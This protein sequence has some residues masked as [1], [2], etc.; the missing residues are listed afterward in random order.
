MASLHRDPRGRSPYWFVAYRRG[1]GIR[2]LKSTKETNLQCA[3][4]VAQMFVRVAEEE[5]RADTTKDLLNGIV[6][7]TLRRLGFETKPEPTA[8]QFLESWLANELASVS[9][10]SYEKYGLVIRQFL[11]SLRSPLNR[12]SP[13]PPLPTS[14]EHADDVRRRRRR[15]VSKNDPAPLTCLNLPVPETCGCETVGGSSFLYRA[16]HNKNSKLKENITNL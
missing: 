4:I 16:I 6:Q 7:D 11:D 1:D 10:T 15:T 12:K 2:T 9:E 5:R 8:R 3:R 13:S 14:L